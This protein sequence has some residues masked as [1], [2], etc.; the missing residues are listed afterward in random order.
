MNVHRRTFVTGLAALAAAGAT[1]LAAAQSWPSRPISIVVAYSAGGDTDAMARLYAEKL[2]TALGRSVIVENKPGAGG[3]IGHAFVARSKPDGHTLVLAPNP[4]VITPHVLRPSAGSEFDPVRDFTPIIQDNT[5]PLVMITNP[6]SGI[7]SLAQLVEAAR[8]N[9]KLSYAS[10]GS[11]SPMHVVG[12]MLNR[13]AG[14]QLV[15][16]PYKGT[17]P[18]VN[19]V[20]GGHIAVGWVTPGAVM[21]HVRAG[22]LVA[23]ATA[24]PNRLQAMPAVPTLK[25]AGYN[26][27]LTAWMGLLGP[28]GLPGDIVAVLNK[29]M[30]D[31]LRMPDVRERMLSLGIEPVGGSP[32]VLARRIAE[33]NAL[34]GR[35]T[36]EFGIRAD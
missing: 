16:V 24:S 32:A 18:V 14:V 6:N 21:E 8:A 5:I 33:D 28:S 1:G 31:I 35:L 11:G 30:N 34:Y 4:L 13:E 10:T 12:E 26:I 22:R 29:H 25:E 3:T 2:S 20:L 17:A 9:P 27:E 36:K 7:K 19:D 23:L 15:H